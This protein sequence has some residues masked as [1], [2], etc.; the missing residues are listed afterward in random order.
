MAQQ[1]QPQQQYQ[2]YNEP[3]N[4]SDSEDL[5]WI[6]W[7]CGLKGNEFYCEVE[8]SFIED[9]FNLTGLE[10]QVRNYAWALDI[11]LDRAPREALA[12]NLVEAVEE[13]AEM[14]YGLIHQ[15]YILTQR[16][17]EAMLKKY[18][19]GIL[20]RCPRVL[21][22]GQQTLPIGLTPA[23][24]L[25]SV[26]LYC[27]RCEEIYASKVSRHIHIDGALFWSNF[28]TFILISIPKS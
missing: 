16:G 22:N 20:G 27:P 25:E 17:L 1:Q 8:E 10:T 19:R 5:P 23:V 24:G 9:N 4:E 26:R 7:Y 28:P 14:L 2:P 11:I 13:D 12:P 15:R 18:N 6:K 21:C 3:D